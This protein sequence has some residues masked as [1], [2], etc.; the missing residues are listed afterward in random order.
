MPPPRKTAQLSAAPPVQP[1]QAGGFAQLV[2]SLSQTG[3]AGSAPRRA[4]TRKPPEP[5]PG[6]LGEQLLEAEQASR[7][8]RLAFT[9]QTCE[10]LWP[11][12]Q[13]EGTVEQQGLCQ[14]L[15]ALCLQYAGRLREAVQAGYAAIACFERC[16]PRPCPV[17]LLRGLGLHSV[18]LA[19]LG[20]QTEV[21][22]LLERAATLL[23]G[24]EAERE[25]CIFWNNAGAAL[26]EL[27]ELDAACSAA[28]Q[29][30]RLLPSGEPGLRAICQ[31]NLRHYRLQQ[32]LERDH[33]PALR[34]ALQA[35]LDGIDELARDGQHHL[36]TRTAE[37]AAEALQRLGENERALALLQR[38]SGLVERAGLGS[39]R[40]VLELNLARLERQA[41]RHRSA[42]AHMALALQ[43]LADSPELERQAQAHLEQSAL[44]E[45]QGHWRAAL[46]SFKR[47]AEAQM[48][49]L[50][51]Q[52]EGRDAV[53]AAC[54]ALQASVGPGGGSL[55][56]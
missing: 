14:H 20:V 3:S 27:G 33:S 5:P 32:A 52:A 24:I 53:Q 42:A 28:E 49:L 51:R 23:P 44:A 25:H 48:T 12:L 35:M 15:L 56:G 54:L 45:A 1:P 43:L 39:D 11:Q 6:S 2:A 47:H 17:R 41:G 18:S 55:P 26:H 7:E 16:A 50:K 30:L 13:A 36:L 37:R 19:R 40:G 8:G 21:R 46:D 10:R 9:Q 29:A 38:C 31:A 34:P 22:R 4:R